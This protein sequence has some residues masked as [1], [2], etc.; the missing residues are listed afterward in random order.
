MMV[1]GYKKAGYGDQDVWACEGDLWSAAAIIPAPVHRLHTPNRAPNTPE[2]G[3]KCEHE[4][5]EN[6]QEKNN[7]FS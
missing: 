7:V 6:Y 2:K 4:I 5:L 3:V 1:L